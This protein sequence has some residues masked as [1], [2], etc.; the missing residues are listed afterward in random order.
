[1]NLLP[2]SQIKELLASHG[3]VPSKRLGQNFLID[4]N[5]LAKVVEAANLQPTDV[6]LE[7]GPG[8]GTLTQAL[9]QKVRKVIAIEKDAGM[10][11]ILGKTLKDFKNIEI[12]QGDALK[13]DPNPYTLAPYKVV[14]NIPYYITS[15][16]IRKFLETPRQPE[17]MVLMLQKE[18]A[19]RIVARPPDMSIL[20]VSVQFYAEAKIVSYVSK[21]CFWPVPNVDSAIIAIRS[22]NDAKPSG[23][24]N[25]DLFF[26]IVRAGFSQPRKQLGGNLVKE[27]KGNKKGI[28]E[29]LLANNI[30]PTQRAETLSLKDWQNL[31][32]N[33]PLG[34]N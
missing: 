27:L 22:R 6:I 2:P 1:M 11:D 30:Q 19:Q 16:L 9:A 25:T 29:W 17:H 14:A 18:V 3:A 15:P 4:K 21:G 13:L 24:I 7:I 23:K 28:T 20:A 26:R 12:V 33:S 31:T 34:E 8:I 5:A 32:K 10:V